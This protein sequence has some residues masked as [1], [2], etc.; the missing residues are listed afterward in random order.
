MKEE[1]N[2]NSD[3]DAKDKSYTNGDT[4]EFIKARW[5]RLKT[6]IMTEVINKKYY[7]AC[8]TIIFESLFC[9]L[10]IQSL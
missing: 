6:T 8:R 4:I 9:C 10:M 7:S 1:A 5:D 3:K 2:S